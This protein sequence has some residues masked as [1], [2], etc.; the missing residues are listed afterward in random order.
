MIKLLPLLSCLFIMFSSVVWSQQDFNNFKPLVS[1]GDIP[2]DFFVRTS[3]KVEQD[4]QNQK[5]DLTQ[6]EQK[7]FLEG[8]HYGIDE[9]LQSGLVIYGDDISNYVTKWQTNSLK[10]SPN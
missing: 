2:E 7:I 6:K 10:K 9:I 8:V 1:K 5:E 4:M 3:S